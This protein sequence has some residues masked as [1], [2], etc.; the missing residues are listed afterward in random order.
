MDFDIVLTEHGSHDVLGLRGEIDVSCHVLLKRT[1][2]DRVTKE[3]PHLVVDLSETK[4]LDS[5]ALGS[6]IAARRRTHAFGGSFAIICDQ[7]RLLKVFE[8]TRLNRVFAVFPTLELWER[9]VG[10]RAG[11]PGGGSSV[12]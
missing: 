12:S 3:R 6:L 4:F 8:V 11:L 9:H 7:A 10:S 2:D 1:I 5:T